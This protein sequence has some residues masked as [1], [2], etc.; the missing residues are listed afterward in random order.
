MSKL[1]PTFLATFIFAL[2]GVSASEKPF[3]EPSNAN[4]FFIFEKGELTGKAEASLLVL[5]EGQPFASE[6]YFFFGEDQAS[7]LDLLPN[8]QDSINE[9]LALHEKGADILFQI[10]LEDEIF[11]EAGMQNI[12]EMSQTELTSDIL[13]LEFELVITNPNN[14]GPFQKPERVLEDSQAI[15]LINCNDDV[16]NCA[17]PQWQNTPEC[18]GDP[19]GDGV[20]SYYDN[21]DYSYN[22]NQ[23][24]CDGDGI[25]D[26][27]DAIEKRS[28]FTYYLTNE[29]T[30][31]PTPICLRRY[32]G[33]SYIY[34]RM[35]KIFDRIKRERTYNCDGE[36]LV[37]RE[38][39]VGTVTRVCDVFTGQF[40][41][42][43]LESPKCEF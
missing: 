6:D 26:A 12:I 28:V 19:D 1:F 13:S 17:C 11:I 8:R 42:S 43:G 5:V 22:P 37:T 27:C 34:S 31:G 9:L 18:S 36:L 25:G 15:T 24:D 39:N 14:A 35:T 20:P 2:T 32:T 33:K 23:A 10:Y 7:V 30:Y 16:R 21:C 4:L 38:T 3:Q 41:S 40:C 29:R